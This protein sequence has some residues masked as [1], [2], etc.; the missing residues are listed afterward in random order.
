MQLDWGARAFS[1]AAFGVSPKAFGNA[2][3]SP[4]GDLLSYSGQSAGDQNK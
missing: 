1:L 3:H 4:K 2:H